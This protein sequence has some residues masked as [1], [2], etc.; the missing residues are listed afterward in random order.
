MEF[1]DMRRFRQLC[2]RPERICWA[3]AEYRGQRSICPLGWTMWTSGNPPMMAISVAPP[4][5]T[6]DL[7]ANSGEFVLAWPGA[8]LAEAT[9]LCGT[10]SGRSMDKFAEC[11]LTALPAEKV[12][13]PLVKEC[14]ANLEC[15]VVNKMTTGDHTVFAGEIVAVHI[16]NPGGRLLLSIDEHEGYEFLLQ[17]GGYR[18]GVIK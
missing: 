6:H 7:I 12:Q 15:K 9:L 14:L 8:E 4:R 2:A 1:E 5:F 10:R 11:K 17:K 13:A 16:T 3:V 18:F